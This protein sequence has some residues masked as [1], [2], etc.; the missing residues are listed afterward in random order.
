MIPTVQQVYTA[1]AAELGDEAQSR[2]SNALLQPRYVLAYS[3]LFRALQLGQSPR[4][5][6]EC[7]YNVPANTSYIDPATAGM[8]NVG[9][10]ESIEERGSLQTVA[11]TG[12][13]PA[14]PATGSCQLMVTGHPFTTGQE[15]TTNG[16]T[17]L[18]DDVNDIFTITV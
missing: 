8:V 5:R 11:I 18:T 1:A 4:I 16:I 13:L 12:A 14:T 15:V 2:W 9:E 17:G 10:I 3:D 6:R 7:Y